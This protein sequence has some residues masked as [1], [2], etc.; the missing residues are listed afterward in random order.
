[1]SETLDSF[2]VKNC[3]VS[4]TADEWFVAFKVP[5]TAT[6]TVKINEIVGV[7]L[8]IKTLATLSTGE[9]YDNKRA[10]RRNKRKLRLAQRQVSNK[11]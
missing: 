10:F 4:R 11:V 6:K 2:T 1:M 5:F 7:D 8:G 3:V 9:T